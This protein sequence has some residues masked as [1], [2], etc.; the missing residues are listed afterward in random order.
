MDGSAGGGKV[1][2]RRPTQ[3]RRIGGQMYRLVTNGAGHMLQRQQT[4]KHKEQQQTLT[5]RP[6]IRKV[7]NMFCIWMPRSRVEDQPLPE[8]RQT[9]LGSRVA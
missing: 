9:K 7:C 3:L 8:G 5:P 6:V 4:P 2:A 1:V